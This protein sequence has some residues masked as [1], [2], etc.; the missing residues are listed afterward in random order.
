MT[1]KTDTGNYFVCNKKYGGYL[2]GSFKAGTPVV[3]VFKDVDCDKLTVEK[4]GSLVDDNMKS[5]GLNSYLME[6]NGYDDMF[7]SG[8]MLCK[9]LKNLTYGMRKFIDYV[10]K[11]LIENDN[12][13]E[14][15]NSG[16]LNSFMQYAGKGKF[17]F[18]SH[19]SVDIFEPLGDE[20]KLLVNMSAMYGEGDSV[21]PSANIY[22]KESVYSG[23]P[24]L[25]PGLSEVVIDV[26]NRFK[27]ITLDKLEIE[28]VGNIFMD[29]MNTHNDKLYDVFIGV[30]RAFKPT[31]SIWGDFD[32]KLNSEYSYV[33]RIVVIPKK[34]CIAV[35]K[36]R[37]YYEC[38]LGF[39]KEA[40]KELSATGEFEEIDDENAII[41]GSRTLVGFKVPSWQP[42]NDPDESKDYVNI[43]AI[44]TNNY[45]TIKVDDTVESLMA[46]ELGLK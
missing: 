7:I 24:E 39:L 12:L 4:W 23:N 28:V 18:N 14:I 36:R 34:P 5:L 44:P 8:L 33:A 43:K 35:A 42:K 38:L 2:E 22:S 9:K 13:P 37:S 10:G 20:D 19:Y 16:G 11:T 1:I 30:D 45:C 29:F 26:V 31:C 6:L 3:E 40:S 15:K 32:S 25:P 41:E 21:S 46:R 27:G 17:S